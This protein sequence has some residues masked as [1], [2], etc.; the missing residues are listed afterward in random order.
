MCTTADALGKVVAVAVT[1]AAGVSSVTNVDA[2]WFP[3]A[4]CCVVVEADAASDVAIVVVSVSESWTNVEGVATTGISTFTG[5]DA[6]LSARAVGFAWA[7]FL[8]PEDSLEVGLEFFALV[9]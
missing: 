5:V 9:S 8:E 1:A 7:P 4:V 2:V 3:I 6:T